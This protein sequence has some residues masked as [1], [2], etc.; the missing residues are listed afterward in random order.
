MKAAWYD[1]T[2]PAADV[3]T[4]GELPDVV[5]GPGQVRIRL[6]ASG[7]NTGDVK[8]RR[9]W[10]GGAMPY[11]RVIP[12]SDGAGVVDAVGAD[13]PAGRVGQRVWCFG[14]QSYRAFGTAAEYVAVPADHAVPLPDGVSF[15]QGACLGIP[16]ITAHRA[17][18]GDGP[19]TGQ[20]VLVAGGTGAV[21]SVAVQLAAWQDARVLAT[22][23]SADQ[24]AAA[25]AY[26]A[27]DVLVTDEPDLAGRIRALCPDGVQRIVEVAFDANIALDAAV[28]A[29]G[30]VISSYSTG[31]AHPAVPYWPLCFADAT[32]HLLGS[33][34]FPAMAKQRAAADLTSCLAERR[35]RVPIAARFPLAGIAAAHE[36]VERPRG[37]GRVL[38]TLDA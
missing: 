14:A 32:L 2:G 1:R 13:V 21:G 36:A 6:H 16:G 31:N 34:D 9:G 22:V 5:P 24:V 38:V 28:L 35:L 33:D 7:V 37:P 29:V 3:L 20:T 10:T 8:K 25:R 17:V 30:G 26:G 15:D 19:V 11:P 23:R 18:C 12:H 4:V 27:S